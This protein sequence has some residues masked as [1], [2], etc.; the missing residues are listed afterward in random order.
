VRPSML[1][2]LD[3]RLNPQEEFKNVLIDVE[4]EDE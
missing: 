1:L 2:S 3:K 4:P